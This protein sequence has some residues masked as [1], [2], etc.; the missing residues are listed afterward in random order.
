MPLDQTALLYSEF[1]AL[2]NGTYR[3]AINRITSYFLTEIDIQTVIASKPVSVDEKD[4]WT[5]ALRTDRADILLEE[6]SIGTEFLVYGNSFVSA[7]PAF[8]RLLDCPTCRFRVALEKVYHEPAFK[9]RWS[10]FKFNASCPRCKNRGDWSV[11]DE[12][13]MRPEKMHI[14]RWSPHEMVLEH[15]P[16]TDDVQHYW[17]IPEDYKQQVRRG[18]LFILKH[19]PLEILQAISHNRQLF[20]FAPGEVFHAKEPTLAGIRN[21]GWG[22]PR[23][24]SN[25]RQV[26]YVQMLHKYNEAIAADYVVPFRVITPANAGK[27]DA[28]D[29]LMS[30]SGGDFMYQV[31]RMLQKRRYNPTDWFT[32]GYPVQYQMLGG[33]ARQLAPM[34]L[35]EQGH[36]HLL[37][38]IG[39]PVEMYRGS[40]QLTTSPVSLRLF[41]ASWYVLVDVYNNFL[42]WF[43]NKIADI[44]QWEKVLAKHRRVTHADDMQRTMAALQMA[45]SG[46]ASMTSALRTIGMEYRDEQRT[47]LEEARQDQEQQA[48]LQKEMEQA[49]Y[50]QEIIKGSPSQT[51]A[52]AVPGASAAGQNGS[53]AGGAAGAM[54][55][56]TNSIVSMIP[57]PNQLQTVEAVSA[58]ASQLAQ[59]LLSRPSPQ[60]N[61]DLQLIRQQNETLYAAVKEEMRKTRQLAASQGQQQVM[62]ESYGTV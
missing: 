21:R 62:Q 56:E 38:A 29:P 25:F 34:E 41:E 59:V 39:A 60:R 40:L 33:E 2:S 37:N 46:K 18:T 17:R 42:R 3:Q 51:G 43:V 8:H 11:H 61:S 53:A 44:Y 58:T 30:F 36:D 26:W 10:G 16:V 7:W 12:I 35:L 28:S 23:T 14:K 5:S 32:L 55:L 15:C 19:V 20:R 6:Q 4:K 54:G 52:P 48:K 47:I 50:S 49:A 13:D 24:I 1:V 31:R 9:F 27:G 57:G 45:M 22:I